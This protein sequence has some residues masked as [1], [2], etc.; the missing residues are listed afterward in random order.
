MLVVQG[1]HSATLLL[2]FFSV[3]FCGTCNC[4]RLKAANKC[5]LRSILNDCTS[6]YTTLLNKVEM[7]SLYNRCIQNFLILVYK[8]LF[9]NGHPTY[10]RNMFTVHHTTYNLRSTQESLEQQQPMDYTD[11]FSYFSTQ[12]WDDLPDELRNNAFNDFK[13]PVQSLYT[14]D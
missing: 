6:H 13:Q 1:I 10:T 12:Q 9:F 4:E 3:A 14:F 8:S 7:T 2:L 5:S 11:S